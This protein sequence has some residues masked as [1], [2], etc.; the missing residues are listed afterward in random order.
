MRAR[1]YDDMMIKTC[2][3]LKVKVINT[4]I[5]F[6]SEIPTV[7]QSTNDP[8][9]N[10]DGIGIGCWLTEKRFGSR[11]RISIPSYEFVLS[12]AVKFG[13]GKEKGEGLDPL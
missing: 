5:E 9:I 2:F 6:R 10:D 4:D 8:A 7:F 13:D 11:I 3:I 12:R 1:V